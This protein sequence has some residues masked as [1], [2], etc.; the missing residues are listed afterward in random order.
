MRY[1]FALWA[2]PPIVFWGWY[3]LSFYDINFG[4]LILS[5]QMNDLVFNVYGEILGIDPATIPGFVMRA[6]IL[7]TL[8]IAAIWAFRRR[9]EIAR[10]WRERRERGFNVG[11]SP[12]PVPPAE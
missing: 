3:Y 1:V 9:R 12:D 11:P 10:W 7:D 5:R 4:Y 2:T 8:I 6:C